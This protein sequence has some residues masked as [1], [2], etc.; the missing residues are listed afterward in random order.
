MDGGAGV[1]LNSQKSCT[2]ISNS[3]FLTPKQ[4]GE[5]GRRWDSLAAAPGK[6]LSH[7]AGLNPSCG[8]AEGPPVAPGRDYRNPRMASPNDAIITGWGGAA[9]GWDPRETGGFF[10]KLFLKSSSNLFLALRGKILPQ[11]SAT[12]YFAELAPAPHQRCREAAVRGG[13]G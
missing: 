7:G 4:A 5:G 3:P 13:L 10:S 12:Q 6:A 1:A 2:G 11:V 8:M 9:P